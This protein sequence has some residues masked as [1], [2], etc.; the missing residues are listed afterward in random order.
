MA[1][2]SE[3]KTYQK[4]RTVKIARSQVVS[5]GDVNPRKISEDNMKRLRKS[6]R[7]NGLVGPLVWNRTTGHIVGGHQR[8][9]AL[10]SLMHTDDYELEVTEIEL[11]ERD[12]FKLNVVLNNADSQGEFDFTLLGKITG[13]YGLD[14]GEDLGF[15]QEVIDIQFPEIAPIEE[16]TDS[17]ETKLIERETTPEEIEAMRARK[18]AV[19]EKIKENRAEYGD[20]KSEPK[21]ILTIVFEKQSAKVEWLMQHNFDDPETLAVVSFD[22]FMERAF[23]PPPAAKE[24]TDGDSQ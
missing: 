17:G 22:D 2:S 19:R 10:D 1:K 16:L 24:K 3:K 12:E 11:P 6:I 5:E 4:G 23:T 21:G 14:P 13:I 18:K 9:A 20:Y 15:S 7:D 8:L